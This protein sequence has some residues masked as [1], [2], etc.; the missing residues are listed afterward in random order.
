MTM[1]SIL[2]SLLPEGF[3]RLLDQ[4]AER[5]RQDFGHMVSDT[6][7]DGTLI[8]ACDRWSDEV[9]VAGLGR[10]FPGEDVLSEEGRKTVPSS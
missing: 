9:L 10:E 6:K 4:V 8:T 3:S 2:S 5:Q 1:E 7:A